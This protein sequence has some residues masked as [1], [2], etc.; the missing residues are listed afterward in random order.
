MSKRRDSGGGAQQDRSKLNDKL[1]KLLKTK[2]HR[3][4]IAEYELA[5]PSNKR[6]RAA[7]DTFFDDIRKTVMDKIPQGDKEVEAV[8]TA[9]EKKTVDYKALRE[10]V[11]N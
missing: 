3:E 1:R 9:I 4:A 8:I 10:M 7:W 5:T 2:Q 11:W 6:D